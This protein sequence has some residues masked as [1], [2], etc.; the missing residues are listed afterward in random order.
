MKCA[1]CRDDTQVLSMTLYLRPRRP[2][3]PIREYNFCSG[4]ARDYEALAKE[5]STW[6]VYKVVRRL[7]KL[8]YGNLTT[9]GHRQWR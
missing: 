8:K 5:Q 3:D 4:C 6:D 2:Q 9:T 7:R 1:V